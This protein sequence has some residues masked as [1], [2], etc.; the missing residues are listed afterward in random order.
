MRATIRI[1]RLEGTDRW[2]P[3]FR[4]A[5]VSTK[6]REAQD[7]QSWELAIQS[8][9]GEQALRLRATSWV[10]DKPEQRRISY[11]DKHLQLN[12]KLFVEFSWATPG[13][14]AIRVARSEVRVLEVHGTIAAVEVSTS[15]GHMYVENLFLGR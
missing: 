1:S 10:R 14:L 15:G 5:A 12:E 13:K 6:D 3:Y 4:I 11:F 9:K 7:K 2:P 8:V